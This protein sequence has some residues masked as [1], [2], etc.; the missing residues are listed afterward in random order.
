[1]QRT[2]SRSGT[3][4]A[5][6]VSVGSPSAHETKRHSRSLPSRTTVR[7]R[8][9]EPFFTTK[10]VGKGTGQGLA[11]V[12]AVVVTKHAG[13]IDVESTP[14]KGTTFT[15]RLPRIVA[16]ATDAYAGFDDEK[17]PVTASM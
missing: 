13:T 10:P 8:I 2:P 9:F 14:G 11:I 12:Y 4:G 7:A 15:L 5:P 16:P 17:T 3:P 1:M 6:S